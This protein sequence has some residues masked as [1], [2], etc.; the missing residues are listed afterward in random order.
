MGKSYHPTTKAAQV[1]MFLANQKGKW[2]TWGPSFY[3]P[4]VQ[5][6]LPVGTSD[7]VQLR[8]MQKLQRLGLVSGCNCGCR[9]DYSPTTEGLVYLGN[10]SKNGEQIA[11]EWIQNRYWTGY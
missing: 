1:L 9:G 5:A 2:S 3:M 10:D 7:K 4:T 11:K 6:V 8:Y